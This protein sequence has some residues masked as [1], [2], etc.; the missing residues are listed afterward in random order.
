M[1]L[2][3]SSYSLTWAVG[4][5]GYERPASPLSGIDILN[6]AA[7][8]R[9]RLVQ[10]ADNLPLHRMTELELA[11]LSSVARLYPSNSR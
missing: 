6:I 11:K 9:I 2:G 1:K 3:I 10:F 8:N 4:V 5:P 7:S